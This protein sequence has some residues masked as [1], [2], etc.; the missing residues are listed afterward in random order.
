MPSCVCASSLASSALLARSAL[1][2]LTV[3]DL[4]D[5]RPAFKVRCAGDTAVIRSVNTR[6]V[7]LYSKLGGH[8][9]Y[10]RG[11]RNLGCTSGVRCSAVRNF[12]K[13]KMYYIM[14]RN[15]CCK[16]YTGNEI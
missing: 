14:Y 10:R 11:I 4:R 15:G 13:C 6:N 2:P 9:I 1:L 8:C 3:P 12:T 16:M 5:R 7:K